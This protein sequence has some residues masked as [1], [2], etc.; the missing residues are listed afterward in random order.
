V[1]YSPMFVRR[2]ALGIAG[3]FGGVGRQAISLARL[4]DLARVYKRP[5]AV[6]YLPERPR[7]FDAMRDSR[8]VEG[9]DESVTPELAFQARNNAARSLWSSRRRSRSDPGSSSGRRR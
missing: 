3:S 8:R 2:G 7:E 6:F 1:T 5:L 4:R 9:T